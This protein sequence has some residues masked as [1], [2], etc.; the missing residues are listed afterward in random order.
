[1]Q[2]VKRKPQFRGDG[3]L[4]LRQYFH[5]TVCGSFEQEEKM[6]TEKVTIDELIK[7]TLPKDIREE[8]DRIR[9][10]EAK[11][12]KKDKSDRFLKKKRNE[13]ATNA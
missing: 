1:M 6:R 11:K 8:I 12:R 4:T 10:I 7:R 2:K 9:E 13:Q 5:L 3:T